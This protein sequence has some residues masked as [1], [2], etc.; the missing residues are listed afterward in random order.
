MTDADDHTP[1]EGINE[2]ARTPTTTHDDVIPGDADNMPA[3]PQQSPMSP[4]AASATVVNL[5]LATGPFSYPP[6]YV[7][8][9]P[10]LSC[11][12]MT[13]TCFLAYISATFM[14]EAISVSHS[15]EAEKRERHDSIFPADSYANESLME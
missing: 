6:G 12:I 13:C 10:F 2:T 3:R 11:I 9:G 5:L 8:L 15:K 7:H 14:V 1:L 4:L